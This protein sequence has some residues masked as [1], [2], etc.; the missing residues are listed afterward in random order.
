[1]RPGNEMSIDDDPAESTLERLFMSGLI[2]VNV[3][4]SLFDGFLTIVHPVTIVYPD[5]MK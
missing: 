1:M 2:T 3:A 4:G 5:T